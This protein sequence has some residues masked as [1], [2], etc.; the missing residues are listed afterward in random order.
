LGSDILKELTAED[1]KRIEPALFRISYGLYVVGSL[2]GNKINAQICNTAFQITSAPMRVAIGVNKNNLTNEYIKK[3]GFFTICV[4]GQE[5]RDMVRNFGFRSG[6]DGDKFEGVDY[7]TGVTGAPI[8]EECI[9]YMECK[10]DPLL[11]LE[12]GTHTMFVGEVVEGGVKSDAEPMTY[13]FY[14][15]AKN[16]PVKSVPPPAAVA[17]AKEDVKTTV[18]KWR[19][20]VCGYI[21]EGDEPPDVCPVCGVTKEEFELVA[22]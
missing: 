1:K 18:K 20:K 22:E 8:I 6:R 17:A 2:D 11:T 14:R 13:A 21:H 16:A 19:C 10:V 3:S 12:V 15:Q 4:L 9:S 5:H 7:T